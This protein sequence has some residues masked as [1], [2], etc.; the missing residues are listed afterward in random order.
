MPL[1]DPARLA[2]ERDSPRIV[3]LWQALVALRSVVSF[4]NTGAHP[5][6]ET[7]GML[8]AMRFRDGWD[9]SYACS[10]RGEGG[11][12]DVGRESGAALGALRTAEMEAACDRLDLRM[13]WHGVS[14]D[15]PITDFGFSKSGEE[16]LAKWGHARTLERFV[17]IIRTE[18]PDIICPTFLDVPGQHGHHRAMTQAAHEV[19]A[20]AADPDYADCDLDPWQVKKMYLPA[21]SGAGQAYDDDLPPPPETTRIDGTGRDPV[22]GWPYAR[23]GQQSRAMHAT[24]AMGHWAD[25]GRAY[26]LHLAYGEEDG[27]PQTLRDLGQGAAQDACDAA[28][29]AFP[30]SGAV[31]EHALSALKALDGDHHKV[32]R[33]REQLARVIHL[34]AGVDVQARLADDLLHPGD[35]TVLHSAAYCDVGEVAVTPLL[36]DHWTQDG[37]AISLG[38]KAKISDPYPPVYLPN[39]PAAPCIETVLRVG[40]VD[41]VQRQAFE[42]PPVVIPA[43]SATVTPVGDIVNLASSRRGVTV[44][45]RNVTPANAQVG[46][47][48]PDGWRVGGE[49][50]VT[51]PD[52]AEVGLYDLT[53]TLD[54]AAAQSVQHIEHPHTAPRALFTPVVTQV[55]VMEVALPNVC[56]GYIGGGNDRV[57]HWLARLGCDVVDLSGEELTEAALAGCDTLV[58]GI[59]AMRFRKGLA[60]AMPRIH[61]WIA[62]GGTLVTLYHRPWDNWDADA[63]APLRLEIGQPSLRWRVTD[64]TAEVDVLQPEHPLLNTPNRIT[65][66]DWD[67]WHKERGLYFAKD[68][69]A[70]YVPLLAMNDAGEAPLKG[71]LL[72]AD[73][74]QGR[75]VHTSLILH[76]QMEKLT[77]G[78]FRLMANLIAKR[79]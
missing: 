15:D 75:H 16:T 79:G 13:Y 25:E 78:A 76:H 64:E 28:V 42:V 63:T 47:K 45:A 35:A 41:V 8:A 20:L 70:G 57:G 59:F 23:I 40:D 52:S 27:L 62:A 14:P 58:I 3:A 36:P 44:T 74:G 30:D 12:N 54:G 6:D 5:D 32:Q 68:W 71:A 2:A 48:A 4:M 29:A 31:L 11:Q 77:E 17:W 7:S 69:D 10:T 18:R 33:K 38:E 24:Q 21:W 50:S 37:D 49:G 34:A 9:I 61:A 67:G 43:R 19:I 39:Q 60:E 73:I 56:V 46:V 22:T 65:G 1:T 66:A 51:V 55:R 72:A 53:L 26:P